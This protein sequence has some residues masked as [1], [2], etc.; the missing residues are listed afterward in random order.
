[1]NRRRGEFLPFAQPTMLP[2]K[3]DS[4]L[5]YVSEW[6]LLGDFRILA[7]TFAGLYH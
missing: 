4:E 5:R 1:M 7:R 3:L 2:A 6:T